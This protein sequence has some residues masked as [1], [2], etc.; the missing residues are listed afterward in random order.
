MAHTSTFSR[1]ILLGV[2]ALLAGSML[3]GSAPPAHASSMDIT[4]YA[5]SD[6]LGWVHF[7]GSN[8][9]V[10]EDSLT[11]ALSGYAWSPY[12]GSISFNSATFGS[13]PSGTCAPTVNITT[14]AVTGWARSCSAFA[15]KAH[16]NGA[17]S[18]DAGSGGWDGWIHLS[19]SNYG[20]TQSTSG[21]T[22]GCW[23]GY[24]YG[25][26]NVGV[27]KFGGA[28]SSNVGTP[29][30][31]ASSCQNGASNFPTCTTCP[32][33]QIMSG[34]TCT[35]SC[36]NGASNPPTC[37]TFTDCTNGANNPPTCTTF[38]AC[39][40]DAD[41][42]PACNTLNGL[43]MNGAIDPPYCTTFGTPI[44]TL[45]VSD[46]S[47]VYG[48]RVLLTW[49]SVGADTCTAGGQWSNASNQLGD[50]SPGSGMTDPLTSD[51]TFTFQCTGPGGTS[52]LMSQT[53]T[54]GPQTCSNGTN[55]PP[56]CTTRSDGTCL[57]NANN[58]PYCTTFTV[59]TATL[60]ADPSTIDTGQSSTLIWSS[61]HAT[62]CTAAGGFSTGGATSG[63]PVST[64][65]LTKTSNYQVTCH[66]A[67]GDSIPATATVTVL[68]P[69][70]S[71]S[72]WP[73]RVATNASTTVTWTSS[74]VLS[75][76]ITRNG[77]ANWATGK[78]SS[79]VDS[80]LT[81]QTIYTLSCLT[82]GDPISQSA[83][84]NVTPG[85]QEF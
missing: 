74:Q 16:C 19:G 59:P 39:T 21:A 14:G 15:D 35:A 61:T 50:P 41:N 73:T 5:W 11:G 67:G 12:F 85:F 78:N 40:N 8:Y 76:S 9:G 63:G 60:Q 49:S 2:F 47:V 36:A 62:S 55:N 81:T 33:G 28:S 58:P 43:C 46:S 72:A 69:N 82:N 79:K 51:T 65:V 18:L 45:S 26:N 77:V 22:N 37:T 80:S 83:T 20:I 1:A 84:V 4:G 42:P 52:L 44:A 29:L 34:G 70:L 38:D 64:G 23:T 27:I 30:C 31:G 13:C 17:S 24:A 75:C 54:V 7:K 57:N 66:G 3:L 48:G 68:Q 53:V 25:S 10:T 32:G 71:I 6:Y 56:D